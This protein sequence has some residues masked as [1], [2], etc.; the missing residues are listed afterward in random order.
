MA[1]YEPSSG[2]A[3]IE[4]I[5]KNGYNATYCQTWLQS[6]E[7]VTDYAYSLC[8]VGDTQVISYKYPTQLH[9]IYDWIADNAQSKKMAHVLGLGD[10]TEK[11]ESDEWTNAKQAISKLDGVVPYTLVRGN[12]DKSAGYNATFGTAEYKQNFDGF[13]NDDLIETSYRL[14]TAGET[15]YLLITLDFGPTDA[16]LNWAGSIMDQ[17]PDRKVIVITHAFLFRDGTTLDKGDVA[18]ANTDGT[19]GR[20][21]G[22]EIWDK[23]IRKHENVLLV[24]SG[25]DPC[26]PIVTT[27]TK[28]DHSNTVTQMLIDPQG[29][30]NSSMGPLGMVAMLYFSEDGRTVSVEY[31]STI[32][33]QYFM[34]TNQFTL[35][36][37]EEEATVESVESEV[38]T[39]APSESTDNGTVDTPTSPVLPIVIGVAA[40]GTV[41]GAVAIVIVKRK[42]K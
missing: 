18:P 27:Q 6:K 28:G 41:A 21:N 5:S 31:Y 14:F 15:D 29:V 24:L 13:Y 37:Y 17:Y 40:A 3:S 23:L 16:E 25:H 2:A 8:V 11:S 9:T 35:S 34:S 33:K 39:T 19:N 42:R 7:P 38:D 30:D 36:L 26:A 10:I 1:H 22:D 32:K 20:N 12:H 4:D